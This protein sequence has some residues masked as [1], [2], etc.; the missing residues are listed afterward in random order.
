MSA[1]G[2]GEL[3][4]IIIDFRPWNVFIVSAC[5]QCRNTTS[6]FTLPPFFLCFLIGFFGSPPGR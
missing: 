4:S 1:G 2:T 6:E 3:C 5:A